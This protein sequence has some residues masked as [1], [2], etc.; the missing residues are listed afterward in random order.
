VTHNGPIIHTVEHLSNLV[1]SVEGGVR[2]G[3]LVFC[4]LLGESEGLRQSFVLLT[5]LTCWRRE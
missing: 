1:I 3:D 2:V 4:D 5:V